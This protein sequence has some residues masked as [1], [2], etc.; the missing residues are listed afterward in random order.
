MIGCLATTDRYLEGY[1]SNST[2]Q[3]EE[4]E[5]GEGLEVDTL[6]VRAMLKVDLYVE[7]LSLD[8]LKVR[9]HKLLREEKRREQKRTE[10]NRREESRGEQKRG[11]Q[12]RTEQKRRGES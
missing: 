12:K 11:E 5:K 1:K 3:I 7:F 8:M 6:A 9:T 2:I 10:E 4:R